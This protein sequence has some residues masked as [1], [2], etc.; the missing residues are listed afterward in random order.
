L[1]L[2]IQ[3]ESGIAPLLGAIKRAKSRIDIVVFRFDRPEIESALKAAVARGVSVNALIAYANRGGE[4]NLRTLE[5]R[6]LE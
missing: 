2:L 5:M 1:K 6:L 3:P 4:K